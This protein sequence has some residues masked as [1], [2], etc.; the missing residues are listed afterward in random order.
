MNSYKNSL[1]LDAVR[2]LCQERGVVRTYQKGEFFVQQ[3]AVS[4]EIAFVEYGYFQYVVNGAQQNSYITGFAFQQEFVA[5]Y[6]RCLYGQ[7]SDVSIQCAASAKVYLLK[8]S[9]L[10]DF[11]LQSMENAHLGRMIAE[12]IFLQT[13]AQLCSLYVQTP[14]ERYRSL[15]LRCPQIVQQIS[16][17]EMASFL[18]VTP[19]TVSAIRRKITFDD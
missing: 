18:R 6:P 10:L 15:L 9:L 14:A 4:R 1:C 2:R 8:A 3:G 16:L 13:Y 7:V 5:D 17:K 12:Q 19:T 11:Y